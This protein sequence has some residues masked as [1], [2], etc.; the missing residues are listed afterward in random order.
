MKGCRSVASGVFVLV[1]WLAVTSAITARLPAQCTNLWLPGDGILGVAGLSGQNGSVWATTTWD[2][3][4]AGP[5]TPVLVVAGDFDLAGST[6]AHRIATWDPATGEWSALGSGMDSVVR[7]LATLPNGDLVAG[8]IFTT[9]G[10]VS[11]R[12]IARWN[13]TAWSPLGS[14]MDD[15]VHALAT[16]PNGDLVAGGVFTTADSDRWLERNHADDRRVLAGAADQGFWHPRGGTDMPRQGRSDRVFLR[17]ATARVV[18]SPRESADQ[19]GISG[20]N[21]HSRLH[22]GFVQRILPG[23]SREL[24]VGVTEH[25]RGFIWIDC[26]LDERT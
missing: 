4:G 8:G 9:A 17:V 2:P 1:M 16:L 20:S 7:T 3:D 22:R 18:G 25:P 19:K 13:G 23:R 21:A 10:G 26:P 5:A 15:Q 14:G 12:R 24:A 11:A 6:L